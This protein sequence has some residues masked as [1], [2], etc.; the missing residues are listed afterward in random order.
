MNIV[1][2]PIFLEA[3]LSHRKREEKVEFS[4]AVTMKIKETNVCNLMSKAEF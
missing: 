2:F 3:Q 1:N 4:T